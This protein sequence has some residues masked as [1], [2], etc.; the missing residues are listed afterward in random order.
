VLPD[1]VNF[2]VFSRHATRVE[3][4]LYAGADSPEPFQVI[5]L[6]PEENRTFFFWHVF[7]EGLPPRTCYTWRVGGPTD[8]QLTGRR[9]DPRKELADP[10][11]RAVSDASWDRRRAADPQDDGH[12]ALRAIVT[13]PARRPRDP[14]APRSLEGAIVY[15]LHVGGFTRHPSSGAKHPGT[16]A[17]LIEK[18]PYLR[19]LGVTHVELLPVMAFDEQDVPAA[20]AARGLGNYWGYSTHSF[21]SPHPRYCIDPARADGEFRALTDALH[22]A[23]IG[24]LLD[25]V[26]NHTA[27]GGERGPVI[28]FKGLANE[29][30]YHLD[31]ADRRRYRDYTGCG[32][33]LNCNH[34]LVTPF[35]VHSLE[36]WVEEMGVDGFRFDLASVF[37][38]DQRGEL[39]ADPPLP[40][41]IESSRI[42][43]HVPLIAEA[44]DAAGLYHVGA[45]PGMAW[46]EWNARYRDVVRRFV[47]G[48]PGLVGEV[49][50]RI[51]GSA[52]LYA[53]DGRLPE[54]SINLI[55][56]HDGF[57]LCDL[58]S[59]NAKHNQANGEENRDGS[60]DNLSWNCG[61]EGEASDPEIVR[62]R[63]GQAK[64]F[65]AILFL[66]QGVPM[67]LAG[68]EVLRSQRGNNNAYCQDNELSWFDWRLVDT[69]REM[70]RF[71]GELIAL[72]KRHPSL[73]RQ[74]FLTG[75]PAAGATQPDAAWHGE[76]LHEPPW[77]DGSA[78][79]LAFTLAGVRTGEAPLHA[80]LNMSDVARAVAVPVFA[81]CHWRRALDT[82]LA[83]PREIARP[84]QQ[85]AVDGEHYVVRSRSVVV[86]EA[87]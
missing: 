43:S 63:R 67:I 46:A 54:N 7:V 6:A 17:G 84:E 10:W 23:G 27:E 18:I 49:A 60:N 62:L 61:A 39:M 73:R 78:Q 65:M 64:N 45:F 33:T 15:E 35:I 41:A 3:L 34:P 68:D 50:T 81:G 31:A 14:I 42:L 52:D 5:A 8:T 19:E 79:L 4:L 48:D 2:C 59:Y 53:D 71:V 83:S 87:G 20:A 55:T 12:A 72:R 29:I 30:F 74:R 57:T 26:F 13:E 44:W 36:Y 9:F 22:D 37:A 70:L 51:A 28:S 56:C 75:R 76:R 11:A 38:R 80:I 47:R 1:G 82:S 86:L 16:F 21:F 77:H 85:T 58:V 66:S 25:V 24:V 32:N 40:W 69:N